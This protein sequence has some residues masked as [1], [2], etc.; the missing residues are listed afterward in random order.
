MLFV[1]NPSSKSAIETFLPNSPLPRTMKNPKQNQ[2]Y[3]TILTS[4]AQMHTSNLLEPLTCNKQLHIFTSTQE[5]KNSI[6]QL[7]TFLSSLAFDK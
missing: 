5:K 1:D 3:S 6:Y 7:T 2:S 4:I